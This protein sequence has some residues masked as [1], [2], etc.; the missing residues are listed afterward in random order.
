MRVS[1]ANVSAASTEVYGDA[2]LQASLPPKRAR[3]L[4]TLFFGSLQIKWPIY[5]AILYGQ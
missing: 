2:M 5:E 4:A 3:I 1:A